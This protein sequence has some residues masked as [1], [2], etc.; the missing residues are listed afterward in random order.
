MTTAEQIAE[1]YGRDGS[2]FFS[3]GGVH[4]EEAMFRADARLEFA[5][6]SEVKKYVYYVFR[7]GSC[8]VISPSD[9]RICK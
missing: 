6:D 3:Q 7:D 1:Q 9:W 8:I 2:R 5:E 4:I